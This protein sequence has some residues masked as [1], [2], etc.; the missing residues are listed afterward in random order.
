MLA[1]TSSPSL[2]WNII[3]I[4]SGH[5]E[6]TAYYIFLQHELTTHL[7]VFTLEIVGVIYP[8]SSPNSGVWT[9]LDHVRTHWSGH[10]PWATRARPATTP[11]FPKQPETGIWPLNG[12]PARQRQQ[13]PSSGP[14][15]RCHEPLHLCAP[16]R[17][18]RTHPPAR[19]HA[20]NY[21]WLCMAFL[22]LHIVFIM[23]FHACIMFKY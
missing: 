23:C 3:A 22:V 7:I 1:I 16:A 19:L 11:S 15:R 4:I 13:Q 20:C 18:S 9:G 2:Q 17:R 5:C 12:Y 10:G 6:H 21:I 8:V 14:T